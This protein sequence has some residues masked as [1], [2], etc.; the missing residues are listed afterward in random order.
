MDGLSSFFLQRN[1]KGVWPARMARHLPCPAAPHSPGA[2]GT[3]RGQYVERALPLYG[4][5]LALRALRPAG[6][7]GAL[8]RQRHLVCIDKRACPP[9]NHAITD[10]LLN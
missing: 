6:T 3:P 10:D 7:D 4:Q 9:Y 8:C 1:V 5:S 2:G